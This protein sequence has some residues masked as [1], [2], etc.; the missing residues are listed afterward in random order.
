MLLLL[1]DLTH[2]NSYPTCQWM[3]ATQL[4]SLLEVTCMLGCAPFDTHNVPAGHGE[5]VPDFIPQCSDA[6]CTP[7]LPAH[8]A[9]SKPT[10]SC[11]TVLELDSL[12][13]GMSAANDK[14]PARVKAMLKALQCHVEDVG[15]ELN[16]PEA[17]WGW[18]VPDRVIR[19]LS[20]VLSALGTEDSAGANLQ[21]ITEL[22]C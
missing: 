13:P 1:G 10:G 17:Q 21:R 19:D 5:L 3:V 15:A 2:N 12:V 9:G 18:C 22:T 4:C 14:L 20:Q 16:L 11:A 8:S 6:L 7:L